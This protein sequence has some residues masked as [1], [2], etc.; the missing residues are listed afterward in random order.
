MADVVDRIAPAAAP[1]K[2]A[3]VVVAVTDEQLALNVLRRAVEDDAAE[4]DL[5]ETAIRTLVIH[6]GRGLPQKFAGI[7]DALERHLERNR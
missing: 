2:A 6:L 7:A 1:A 4:G 5:P 3:P